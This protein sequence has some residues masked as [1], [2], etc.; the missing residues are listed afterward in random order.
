METRF[1]DIYYAIEKILE[2]FPFERVTIAV[3]LNKPQAIRKMQEIAERNPKISVK[4][5]KTIYPQGAEKVLV[6]NVTGKQVGEGK[7]PID[8][9]CVVCNSTTMATLGAFL[10]TG[11][12]LVS[13]C[14]TVDGKC[15]VSPQNIIAPI[16]TAASEL[17]DA[18]GGLKEEPY[19]VLFGGPMM[20]TAVKDL[21]NPVT[22]TTNA[23]LALTKGETG[24][25]VGTACI[26]CG[27]CTNHCPFGINPAEIAVMYNK[28]E[29][30][31]T[32]ALGVNL[33]MECGCCSYICPAR[34]PLVQTIRI[35][36]SELKKRKESSK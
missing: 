6:Y 11:M 14:V 3:E 5:L 30:D 15:V 33:C 7:L 28:G 29:L 36:K 22:K 23:V 19:K 24:E 34:R 16:G 1:E 2:F 26:R 4:P 20:G 18:C 21:D 25:S 12:P 31:G 8:A 17:F 13:K 10:K 27:K 9:G 32:L 35:V